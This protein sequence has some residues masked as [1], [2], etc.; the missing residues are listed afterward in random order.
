MLQLKDICITLINDQRNII[1][2]FSYSL[3][4][5]DKVAIIGEEGNGKSTL[6]KLMYDENLVADYVNYSGAIIKEG[7]FGYLPQFMALSEQELTIEEY[8]SGVDIYS[9][10]EYVNQLNLDYG[11]FFSKQ[12]V[13]TLSGGEKVKIQLLKLLCESPDALFLDEPSND[14]DIDTLTFLETFISNCSVPIVFISHDETLIENAANN[15]IHIEQLVRKTKCKITV[16]GLTYKEYLESRNMLFDKQTQ[17]ALKERSEYKKKQDRLRQLYEKAR[18]NSSWKSPDGIASSDGHARKSMKTLIA[19]GK[20]FER[21]SEEFTEIP[22][23]EEGIFTKFD[24]KIIVPS[25]KKILELSLKELK[26][27]EQILSKNIELVVTGNQHIAIIGNNGIGKSTLLKEIWRQLKDR[28]DL[29]VGYMPQNYSDVLDFNQTP[30]EFF[31][32]NYGK[33]ENTR[34]LTYMGA[35]RFTTDEMFHS[36]GELSG[37]QR[38]KIIFLDIILRK[39]NVLILD[40]PTRNFSPLSA[41]AI[42]KA[43]M[44]FNGTIIS[45]SHDRKYLDEVAEIIYIL[46]S[47]GIHIL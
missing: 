2:G 26:I 35:M 13:K 5:N 42:R 3:R 29:V 9:N 21:E 17:V 31:R 19:K 33:E 23:R 28:K 8:F 15:I 30:S 45:I 16:S 27:G 39:C 41:P 36:I 1:E 10:Y 22:D 40:E 24:E 12:L 34:A 25:S 18:H 32:S 46:S 47:D 37:G 43:L 6:L 20:R 7:K 4:P 14:L 11:F 38:A 44:D